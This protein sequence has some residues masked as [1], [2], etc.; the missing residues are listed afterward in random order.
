M[1]LLDKD[2][3]EVRTRTYSKK[4]KKKQNRGI[5]AKKDI[6]GG[7]IIGDY[8]GLLV[9]A[10]KEDDYENGDEMY[11]MYYNDDATIWPDPKNPGIHILNHSCEPN[12]FMYTYKGH[13]LYFALRKIHKG[14]ELTVSY[15]L[16]P[17]DDECEPCIHAC[18][19][20]TPRCSGTMHMSESAYDLWREFDD[21]ETAKTKT[22]PAAVKQPLAL[23]DKYP[24]T[25]P[26][27]PVYKLFGAENKKP[28]I[29]KT[30]KLPS[31]KILR[32]EIRDSGKQL[33]FPKL[34]LTVAGIEGKQVY[35]KI[36]N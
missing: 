19:C 27:N 7:T 6:P 33:S 22:V 13:T 36:S 31:L 12:C 32:K 8:L 3:W 15:Q 2:T 30:N 29:I 23:L 20:K 26:D 21:A 35:I 17:I 5:F 28:K 14:E 10:E 18:H 16:S 9:P 25:I 34:G 24:D 1:F 4:D 11:L